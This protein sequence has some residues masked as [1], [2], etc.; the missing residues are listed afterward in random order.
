MPRR[1]VKTWLCASDRFFRATTAPVALRNT[2]VSW[3]L[4]SKT[5]LQS[6]LTNSTKI[7]LELQPLET[8]TSFC[9]LKSFTVT[10]QLNFGQKFS[11]GCTVPLSKSAGNPTGKATEL[12][13]LPGPFFT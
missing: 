9:V 11:L 1:M 10:A 6:F 7:S 2:D 3:P 13:G 8:V 4:V 5:G 12:T